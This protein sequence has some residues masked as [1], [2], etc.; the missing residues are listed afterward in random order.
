MQIASFLRKIILSLVA[1]VALPYFAT[2]TLKRYDFR[3]KSI[4]HKICVFIFSATL[5]H[6]SSEKEVSEI[7]S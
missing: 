7:L 6:F 4:E 3:E 2:L 1:C 5:K